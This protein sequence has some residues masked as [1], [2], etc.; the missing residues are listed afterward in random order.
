M[1]ITLGFLQGKPKIFLMF[2]SILQKVKKKKL[3]ISN[4]Q[5]INTMGEKGLIAIETW[6]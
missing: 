5:K 1:A 4:Q 6:E 2:A 3:L